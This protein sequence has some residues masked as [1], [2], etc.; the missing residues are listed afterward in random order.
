MPKVPLERQHRISFDVTK[1]GERDSA[2]GL[3]AEFSDEVVSEYGRSYCERIENTLCRVLCRRKPLLSAAT[4]P[5]AGG[6]FARENAGNPHKHW[7]AEPEG[8][9]PS[10]GLYNPITV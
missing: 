1:V 9:E 8:F 3:A 10:I 7:L 4:A 2:E 5:T 6:V